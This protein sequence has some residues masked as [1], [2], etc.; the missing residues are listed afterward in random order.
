MK[1]VKLP[2]NSYEIQSWF[3]GIGFKNDKHIGEKDSNGFFHAETGLFRWHHYKITYIYSGA[4]N[5]WVILK[6]VKS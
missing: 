3:H 6:K 1:I 4:N 5:D 2:L